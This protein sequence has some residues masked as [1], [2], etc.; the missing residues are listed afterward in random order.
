M[1][2]RPSRDESESPKACG[3]VVPSGFDQLASRDGSRAGF[4]RESSVS[5]ETALRRNEMP[6]TCGHLMRAV[7]V[8]LEVNLQALQGKVQY[9][10]PR[11]G[12]IFW[13]K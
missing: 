11:P 1:L 8:K 7:N 4:H 10:E 13:S 9:G 5:D 2:A 3:P 12:A 6:A